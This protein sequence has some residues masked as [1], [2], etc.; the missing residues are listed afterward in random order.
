VRKAWI[1]PAKD[2][3]KIESEILLG[4]VDLVDIK[5]RTNNVDFG[6]FIIFCD[7]PTQGSLHAKRSHK[8]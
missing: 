8:Q 2:R 4:A 6:G 7:R 3:V 5:Y 1:H